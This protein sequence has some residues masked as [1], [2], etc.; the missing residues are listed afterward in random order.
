MRGLRLQLTKQEARALK[1]VAGFNFT[2]PKAIQTQARALKSVGSIQITNDQRE[3][4]E[5]AL[6]TI[7]EKL[8]SMGI[9]SLETDSK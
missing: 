4:I 9:P 6:E 7:F 2:V 8:C 3:Q 1:T 5:F